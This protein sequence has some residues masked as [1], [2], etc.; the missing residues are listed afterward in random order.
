MRFPPNWPAYIP[1]DKIAGWFEAYAES[2]ELNFWTATEFEGGTYDEKAERW[3]VVVKRSDASKRE[4]HPRHVVLATGV[5]GIRAIAATI[6][7]KT[8][9]QAEPKSR[10]FSVVRR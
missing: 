7:R 8:C 2:M 1:K 5:S 4:M 9:I 6:L 3:S 10:S